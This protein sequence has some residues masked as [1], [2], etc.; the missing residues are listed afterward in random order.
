[1]K[2]GDLTKNRIA[3]EVAA[4][5]EANTDAYEGTGVYIEN[6]DYANTPAKE[7]AST[8]LNKPELVPGSYKSF[9]VNQILAN[10]LGGDMAVLELRGEDYPCQMITLSK[11]LK[12]VGYS[13]FERT[14][15]SISCTMLSAA[16]TKETMKMPVSIN[17]KREWKE[18]PKYER[19]SYSLWVSNDRKIVK[20]TQW[21]ANQIVENHELTNDD[22]MAIAKEYPYI[23]NDTKWASAIEGPK[24]I[25]SSEYD[26]LDELG[27]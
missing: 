16:K 25:D 22:V 13:T 8:K 7:E 21:V 1:M 26:E 12:I 19:K 18:F 27:L 23:K 4:E 10:Q 5:F 17:G 3:D 14:D 9:W 6:G 15:D 20:L 11:G 24:S 2:H